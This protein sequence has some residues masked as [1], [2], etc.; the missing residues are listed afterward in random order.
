MPTSVTLVYV[1]PGLIF[2]GVVFLFL[3]VGLHVGKKRALPRAGLNMGQESKEVYSIPEGYQTMEPEAKR[4]VTI[5]NL[6]LN[7]GE[8][9]EDIATL[10]DVEPAF[11][12]EVLNDSRRHGSSG[13]SLQS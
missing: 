10:L 2:L 11:V 5:Q 3:Y 6:H 4:K 12:A 8:T 1:I 7:Y 9:A 13:R